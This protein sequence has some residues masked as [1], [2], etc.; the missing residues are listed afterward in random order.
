MRPCPLSGGIRD[1]VVQYSIEEG[2]GIYRR[3]KELAPHAQPFQ[4]K[5]AGCRSSSPS[6]ANVDKQY[7]TP[8]ERRL[9]LPQTIG[10]RSSTGMIHH[11][12]V[13]DLLQD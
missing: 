8:G 4:D 10:A 11:A 12:T 3:A 5:G 6:V 1:I 2:S 9:R 13:L 7:A